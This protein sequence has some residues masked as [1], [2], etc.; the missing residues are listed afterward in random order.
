M[1]RERGRYRG[2][3]REEEGEEGERGE[4]EA[5]KKAK[6]RHEQR[7][8]TQQK[9]SP[10]AVQESTGKRWSTAEERRRPKAARGGERVD[11][12]S[13]KRR[14]LRAASRKRRAS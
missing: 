13:V 14:V 8:T 2:R 11:R 3:A 12:G 1:T 4:K 10:V 7:A 5:R 9:E 6:H